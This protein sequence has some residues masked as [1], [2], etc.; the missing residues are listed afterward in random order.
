MNDIC[1]VVPCKYNQESGFLVFNCVE[2]IRNNHPDADIYV[3]DSDSDDISYLQELKEDYG[4]IPL[5]VKNKNYSTGALWSVFDLSGLKHDKYFL[6]HDSSILLGKVDPHTN[7]QVAP[8][9]CGRNWKWPRKVHRDD[10]TRTNEWALKMCT[11][12]DFNLNDSFSSLV[13][14]MFLVS[15]QVL[16]NLRATGFYN[17]R[18]SNKYES[19]CMERLWGNAFCNM[20]LEEEMNMNSLL[21]SFQES[22]IRINKNGVKLRTHRVHEHTVV[23]KFWIDRQ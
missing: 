23:Q 13:G 4:I 6:I 5:D 11:A 22:D 3:V 14:P 12:N 17:I 19:E 21:G 7:L 2:S 8:L 20:G 16:K 15:S 9:M 1:F 10:N 18:P